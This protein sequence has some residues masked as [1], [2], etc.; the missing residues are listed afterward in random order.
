[1]LDQAVVYIR[2]STDEQANPDK[3]SLTQQRERCTGYCTAQ[4]W[5]LVEVYEDAGV[6]GSLDAE[7][8]P[9]LNRLMEDAKAGK[10]QR[11][12]FLKIDR[13]ARSLRKL[14]NTSHQ[15]QAL[16]VG[17]VSVVEQFDTSTASGQLYFNLLGAFAEFERAQ[18]NERM[19]DGRR[20][21]VR[22]GKYLA[23]TT[24]F[25][26]S[27]DNGHLRR[28][29]DQAKVVKQ[30]F[31]WASE[32]MGLKSIVTSLN[33]RGVEPPNSR[34]RKSSWGWHSTTIH[35][36]LTSPRYVGKATY[37][38]QPMP[39]PALVSEELFDAAQ[40]ALKRR[41]I[42]SPRNTKQFYLLQHLLWCRHCGG[43][44]MAKSTWNRS[45]FR[46]VYLCRMRT[47]YGQRAGHDEIKWRWVGEDLEQMIKRY[48]LH[49]LAKPKYL[50][51]DAKVYR[52][53]A[54]QRSAD[55]QGQEQGLQTQLMKLNKQETRTLEGWEKG[56][57]IDEQQ[58]YD[59]LAD[60]RRQQRET[61]AALEVLKSQGQDEE[62]GKADKI[63]LL[64]DW[65]T[66]MHAYAGNR[67]LLSRPKRKGWVDKALADLDQQT[68]VDVVVPGD[69]DQEW[70]T[71]SI[72]I[73]QWWKD[74][75][76]TLVERIWVNDDGTLTVKGIIE[77]A[78]GEVSAS[79]SPRR[80]GRPGRSRGHRRRP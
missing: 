32:G 75:I 51:H 53:Q 25:G 68:H 31:K 71:E 13:M 73:D 45:G 44:Y 17:M 1:M 78:S 41:R 47:T 19:S 21:A 24:P 54:E 2:V 72:P 46:S 49:V 57:Y 14:L 50:V 60:I 62:L 63:R 56:I 69:D 74:T 23:A 18:I 33:E 3:T 5:E 42:N 61:Q 8:R 65:V 9:A 28:D 15:L 37:A 36:M 76:A 22:Q 12:I 43:R 34:K 58:F 79:T 59:H 67:G 20:G 39:C 64:A 52:E 80:W 4:Q 40:S 10:F 29:K 26:Y 7:A 77:V 66:Q 11:V 38:G 55:H 6:S 35:K 16:G 30:M 70:V 48:V 27:R